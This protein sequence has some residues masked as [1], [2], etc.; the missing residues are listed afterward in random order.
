[1]QPSHQ[2]SSGADDILALLK[3]E[4][5]WAEG[6]ITYLGEQTRPILTVVLST[7]DAPTR[8]TLDYFIEFQAQPH[9]YSNDRLSY[10]RRFTLPP[11]LFK[12]MLPKSD[13]LGDKQP[14]P[15]NAELSFTLIVSTHDVVKGHEFL[16]TP[17]SGEAFYKALISVFEENKQPVPEPLLVQFHAVYP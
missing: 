17:Q 15:A 1:M 10:I 12:R 16:L 11:A 2:A 13:I 8:R 5:K 3:G 4:F 9:A 6:K 7:P 14:S